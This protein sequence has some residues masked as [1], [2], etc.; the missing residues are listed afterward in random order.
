LHSLVARAFL[1][2]GGDGGADGET[3]CVFGCC[4]LDGWVPTS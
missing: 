2:Y 1:G 4:I 3:H